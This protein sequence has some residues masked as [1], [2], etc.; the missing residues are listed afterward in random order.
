M[1][2][3]YLRFK[4]LLENRC[5]KVTFKIHALIPAIQKHLQNDL[6]NFGGISRANVDKNVSESVSNLEHLIVTE[7]LFLQFSKLS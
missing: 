2:A 6:V 3:E 7:N 5:D 4:G 1:Y